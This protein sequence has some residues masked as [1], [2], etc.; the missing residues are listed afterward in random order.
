MLLGSSCV[1]ADCLARREE[2]NREMSQPRSEV[3]GCSG[4]AAFAVIPGVVHRG[5]LERGR[6]AASRLARSMSQ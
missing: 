4:F 3:S 6:S 5:W 2:R 1:S